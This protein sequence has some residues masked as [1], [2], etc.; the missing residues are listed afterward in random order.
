MISPKMT[1]HKHGSLLP[2]FVWGLLVLLLLTACSAGQGIVLPLAHGEATAHAANLTWSLP[3][4]NTAR[5][6]PT[7][8]SFGSFT[9]LQGLAAI[10]QC[11]PD[12]K[13]SS[14][15]VGSPG[16]CYPES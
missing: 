14:L 15:G 7:R 9:R 10:Q 4:G 12:R 6:S 13:W 2:W 5:S 11:S 3:G 16:K 1:L 8:L